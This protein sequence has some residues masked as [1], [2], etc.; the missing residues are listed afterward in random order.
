MV[1][2]YLTYRWVQTDR[3]GEGHTLADGRQRSSTR[4]VAVRFQDPRLARTLF[5]DTRWAWV[6]LAPRIYLGVVWLRAGWR[7]LD[8]STMT[9]DRDGALRLGATVET[10]VGIALILGLCTGVAA[11]AGGVL[12]LDMTRADPSVMTNVMTPSLFAV[13]VAVILAWKSAG[14]IGFDRWLLPALGMPWDGGR[15]FDTRLR[16]PGGRRRSD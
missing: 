10:L 3:D 14:W 1:S 16:A 15:L 8:G 13:T 9:A 12:S 4:T 11:I 7:H 2:S 5:A 6:W